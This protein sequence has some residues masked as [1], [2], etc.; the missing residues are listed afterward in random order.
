ME[1]ALKK[2][3]MK[4]VQLENTYDKYMQYN[5]IEAPD[6]PINAECD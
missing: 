6:I 1:N 2:T 4:N 3:L 5:A